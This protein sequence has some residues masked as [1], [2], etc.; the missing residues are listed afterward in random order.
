MAQV[1]EEVVVKD[2]GKLHQRIRVNPLTGEDDIDIV[3]VATQSL[4]Q[5]RHLDSLLGH[6]PTNDLSYVQTLI[7]HRSTVC[8]IQMARNI[9]CPT[10]GFPLPHIRQTFHAV[11]NGLRNLSLMCVATDSTEDVWKLRVKDSCKR[12]YICSIVTFFLLYFILFW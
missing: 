1:G 5:P 9:A 12:Y 6:Y 8:N 7:S 4:R 11:T 10:L 3:A 2:L